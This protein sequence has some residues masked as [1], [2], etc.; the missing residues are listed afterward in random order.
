MLLSPVEAHLAVNGQAPSGDL[1]DGKGTVVESAEP[2]DVR[3]RVSEGPA[4]RLLVLAAELE[5]GWTASVNGE[6]EPI[7]SAWGHQVGVAVPEQKSVVTVRFSSSYRDVLL[8]VQVAALLFAL[9]T[10]I[11]GRR[12]SAVEPPAGS[13][14]SGWLRDRR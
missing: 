14:R 11:P 12:V 5:P 3:V 10:V 13:G 2:P 7:V 1:S 9:F 6:S 4:G 8:L